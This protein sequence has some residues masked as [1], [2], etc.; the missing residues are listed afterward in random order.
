VCQA[1]AVF[2]LAMVLRLNAFYRSQVRRLL[3]PLDMDHPDLRRPGQRC[4]A[5]HIRRGD[6]L[7]VGA[8]PAE[9]C[10]NLTSGL[11][12]LRPNGGFGPCDVHMGCGEG[13]P[14][15]LL[16]LRHVLDKVQTLT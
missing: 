13:T 14:F 2:A 16:G 5:A 3:H 4:V 1:A 15:S 9:Y 6:R 10:R 8:D 11:P 7:I 12:C